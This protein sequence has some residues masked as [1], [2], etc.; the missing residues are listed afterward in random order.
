MHEQ[1]TVTE[2]G[3]KKLQD[4][5]NYLKTIKKQEIKDA[6]KTAKEFGDLSENSEY[7]A[8]RTEQAQVEGRIAELEEMLKHVKLVSEDD[9]ARDRVNVGVKVTVRN[10]STDSVTEYSLVGSTEADPFAN[11]ISDTSPIGKAIIGAK[12]GDKVTVRLPR[13]ETVILIEKIEK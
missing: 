1:I 4:E 7:E 12:V 8:A 5:L 2:E 3:L 9:I 13:G 11:R 10:L 6:I